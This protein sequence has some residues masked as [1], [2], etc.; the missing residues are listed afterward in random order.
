[1]VELLQDLHLG[2]FVAGG[3]VMMAH[4][5]LV[6]SVLTS[7]QNEELSSPLSPRRANF[8]GKPLLSVMP[9]DTSLRGLLR[10]LRL[11]LKRPQHALASLR[12]KELLKELELDQMAEFVELGKTELPQSE[13]EVLL[14]AILNHWKKNE[15][16]AEL[17]YCLTHTVDESIKDLSQTRLV[18]LAHNSWCWADARAAAQWLSGSLGGACL[19]IRRVRHIVGSLPGDEH[20]KGFGWYDWGF[21]GPLIRL[22]PT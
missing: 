15:R 17:E 4:A 21:G 2:A 14:T 11:T 6:P 22:S 3:T 7:S 12:R 1:M 19:E 5:L 18:F 16:E 9:E 10:E 8:N 13:K 20:R